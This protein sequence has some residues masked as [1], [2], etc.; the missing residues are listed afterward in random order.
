MKDSIAHHFR[1]TNYPYTNSTNEGTICWLVQSRDGKFQGNVFF[2]FNITTYASTQS[3]PSL[4]IGS[5]GFIPTN[6]CTT[7]CILNSTQPS[8]AKPNPNQSKPTQPKQLKANGQL[9]IP[10]QF[11]S[12]LTSFRA[13]KMKEFWRHV[14]QITNL[15]HA[16]L[17]VFNLCISLMWL[18]SFSNEKTKLN[19]KHEK[20]FCFRIT[21][22][23]WLLV[24]TL[25]TNA[26]HLWNQQSR[27]F[28]N[29]PTSHTVVH[30]PYGSEGTFPFNTCIFTTLKNVSTT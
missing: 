25:I 15:I 26:S 9:G 21:S 1:P 19:S 30:Q 24:F 28:S 4:S 18:F 12:T 16:L 14:K 23:L 8:P 27:G 7:D 11:Q 10:V 2:F 22:L 20:N 3:V 13:T 5:V 6:T 17:H 29:S